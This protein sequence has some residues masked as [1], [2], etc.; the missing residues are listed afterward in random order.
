MNGPDP[1]GNWF[2]ALPA[3]V[4]PGMLEA[5]FAGAP[6]FLRRSSARSRK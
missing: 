6:P 1:A 5:V 4:D 3:T 2:V